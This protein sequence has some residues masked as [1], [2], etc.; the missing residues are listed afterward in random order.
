MLGFRS[1]MFAST[2]PAL[3]RS[4]S[5]AETTPPIFRLI[6]WFEYTVLHD[7]GLLNSIRSLDGSTSQLVVR[8]RFD[9]AR[10]LWMPGAAI[11]SQHTRALRKRASLQ[12]VDRSVDGPLVRD[13]SD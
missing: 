9:D 5:I 6:A 7:A 13:G 3:A 10:F 2:Q 4:E 12:P 8:D 1:T 11:Q